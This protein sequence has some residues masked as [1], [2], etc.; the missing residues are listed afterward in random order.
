MS[1]CRITSLTLR[2]MRVF[3]YIHYIHTYIQ[4][5]CCLSYYRFKVYVYI[6]QKQLPRHYSRHPSLLI[7]SINH[8][9]KGENEERGLTINNKGA[10]R[11]GQN[12]TASQAPVS[13]ASDSFYPFA[14]EIAIGRFSSRCSRWSLRYWPP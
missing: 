10:K 9:S 7:V 14:P 6:H 4:G 3:Y 8:V 11:T 5:C 13:A 12:V 1:Y 2:F